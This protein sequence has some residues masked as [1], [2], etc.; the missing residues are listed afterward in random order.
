MVI[1]WK[2]VDR[3]AKRGGQAKEKAV[4]CSQFAEIDLKSLRPKSLYAANG[5]AHLELEA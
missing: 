5:G 1:E 3:P 2:G 4:W